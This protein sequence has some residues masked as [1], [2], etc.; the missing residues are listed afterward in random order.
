M[1][2]RVPL[3]RPLTPRETQVV[4]QVADVLDYDEV[5][6]RLSLSRNT[7]KWY[8]VNAAQKIPGDWPPQ[9]RCALWWWG[10]TLAVL[11]RQIERPLLVEGALYEVK[12]TRPPLPSMR[13]LL[14]KDESA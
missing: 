6:R 2:A 13:S 9:M 14:A 11:T 5:A 8:T 1:I 4:E 12:P 10:A 3:L 7:V